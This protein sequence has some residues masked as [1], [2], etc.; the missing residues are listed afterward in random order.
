MEEK[1]SD[2]RVNINS[3]QQ[4]ALFE[5]E[6][7]S[8]WKKKDKSKSK[9]FKMP[10]EVP[11]LWFGI[12][13]L[14]LIILLILFFPKGRNS[15]NESQIADLE[16]RIK[17]LEERVVK[18]ETID[19]KVAQ[20]WEQAKAFEQFKERF[21]R[22]EAS[23]SLRMD[24]I[25]QSI[26]DLKKKLAKATPKQVKTSS[27]KKVTKKTGK[28]RYHTVSAGDTLYGISRKYG[29]TV[30]KIRQLNKLAKSADIHPGQELL[31]TP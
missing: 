30:E 21:D 1:N 23:L 28:K 20:I 4:E 27:Q 8:P 11:F 16:A 22:S 12:G 25:A 5:E 19:D 31:V 7:Y 6:E 3:E 18:L 10:E 9:I 26:D 15:I 14:V 2:F 29:L 24:Q 17:K 13:F